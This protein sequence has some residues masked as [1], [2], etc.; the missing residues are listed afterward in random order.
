MEDASTW[1]EVLSGTRSGSH[2]EPILHIDHLIPRSGTNVDCLAHNNETAGCA[3][4][5]DEA[6]PGV[7]VAERDILEVVGVVGAALAVPV[8]DC[9]YHAATAVP[10][11]KLKLLVP[12]TRSPTFGFVDQLTDR[13]CLH[14]EVWAATVV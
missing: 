8:D 4:I 1:L 7:R 6:S 2:Q 10:G 14:L 12:A 3:S 5:V 13:S 11:H 9:D